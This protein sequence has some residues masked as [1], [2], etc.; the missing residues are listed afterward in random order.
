MSVFKEGDLVTVREEHRSIFSNIDFEHPLL[1]VNTLDNSLFAS[2]DR[3]KLLIRC[4]YK[5][6]EI[7]PEEPEFNFYPIE[8]EFWE[9]EENWI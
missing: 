8:L 7:S 9:D 4:L 6:V 5:P 3:S 1:V 2:S